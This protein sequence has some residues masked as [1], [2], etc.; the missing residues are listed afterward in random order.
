M[1]INQNVL[2]TAAEDSLAVAFLNN[3]VRTCI[4]CLVLFFWFMG[5]RI[6]I[7][8]LNKPKRFVILTAKSQ[9]VTY[10]TVPISKAC[11]TEEKEF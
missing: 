6:F 10:L 8:L 7:I 4:V 2:T 3:I 11:V 9:L 1:T 5:A